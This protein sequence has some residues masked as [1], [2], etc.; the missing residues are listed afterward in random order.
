MRGAAHLLAASIM[1][2]SASLV[3]QILQAIAAGPKLAPI[4]QFA[5]LI[6]LVL[7]MY[8]GAQWARWTVGLLA[9]LSGLLALVGVAALVQVNPPVAVLFVLVAIAHLFASVLLWTSSA[10]RDYVESRKP[11][12]SS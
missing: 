3:L 11:G 2:L 12:A 10:L 9:G 8:R 1:T 5:L 4:V 6:G 7:A